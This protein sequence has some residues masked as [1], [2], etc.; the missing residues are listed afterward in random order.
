MSP[1]AEIPLHFNVK[2]FY[3]CVNVTEKFSLKFCQLKVIRKKNSAENI[4]SRCYSIHWALQT[5]AQNYSKE[6]VWIQMFIYDHLQWFEIVFILVSIDLRQCDLMC[7]S[8]EFASLVYF[9]LATHYQIVQWVCDERV[10]N[11][12]ID[13]MYES[14]FSLCLCLFDVL[15]GQYVHVHHLKRSK[16]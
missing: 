1:I 16:W 13:R 14:F 5:Q 7:E 8:F 9:R 3:Y 2:D 15:C 11:T 12:H 4:M 6:N 10:R